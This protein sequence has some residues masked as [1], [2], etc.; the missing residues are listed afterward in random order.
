[1]PYPDFI[2]AF[3]SIDVPFPKDVVQSAVIR[4]DAGL[5]A[6]FTFLK[7]MELPTHSHGAQW[8]TVIEGEIE[9]TIGG[10]TR[11]YGVGD[12]YTIPSG[13]EHGAKIKAGTRVIDVFEEADRY[14]LID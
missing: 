8:G 1:M 13:V 11:T 6:F 2:T 4:S 12:S 3:P 9:F 14:A 7:D 5:V 10:E